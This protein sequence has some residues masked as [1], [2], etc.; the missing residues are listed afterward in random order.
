MGSEIGGF[1][2]ANLELNKEKSEVR[3][4]ERTSVFLGSINISISIQ[5]GL[6]EQHS[7]VTPQNHGGSV[8][9]RALPTG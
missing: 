9:P 4:L 5:P 8:L 1:A 6:P 3:S 7:G 2:V